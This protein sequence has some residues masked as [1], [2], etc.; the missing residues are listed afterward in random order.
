MNIV[1]ALSTVSLALQVAACL[2]ALAIAQAPGWRRARIVAA[3][4]GTAGLYSLF[5]L[6]GNLFTR[7]EVALAWVTSANLSVAAAHVALWIWF[8]F[9]D[10]EGRWE[11]VPQRLRWFAT[12]H[13]VAAVA[14]SLSRHAIDA[15]RMDMVAVRWLRVE[16]VQPSLTP[17]AT[18]SVLITLALRRRGHRDD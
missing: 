12:G 6:L 18:V 17:V 2:A 16:F 10:G 1:L 8:S 11:S 3:L 14:I 9:S 5:D 13:V 4:A 7:T 15:S